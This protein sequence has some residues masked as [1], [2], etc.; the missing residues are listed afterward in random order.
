MHW[1]V[2]A[3]RRRGRS[4]PI[5]TV[6]P[7]SAGGTAERRLQLLSFIQA[8]A[9][10]IVQVVPRRAVVARF[11]VSGRLRRAMVRVES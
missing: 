2:S 8:V 4:L 3:S 7:V 10:W 9:G 11:R 1:W 5:L 6:W